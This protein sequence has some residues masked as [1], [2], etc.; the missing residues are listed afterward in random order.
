MKNFLAPYFRNVCR[1]QLSSLMMEQGFSEDSTYKHVA[2]VVFTRKDVAIKVTY[3]PEDF[4]NYTPMVSV[5]KINNKGRQQFVGLWAIIPEDDEARNYSDLVFSS[6]IECERSIR[7][8]AQRV[9]NR[10]VYP[11][12][13]DQERLEQTLAEQEKSI[14]N[15]YVEGELTR[16]KQEAFKAFKA[17]N[18]RAAVNAFE[19]IP[20]DKLSKLELIQ[21]KYAMN[22][23]NL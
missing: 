7:L 10:F 4:P 9:I 21:L 3:Y 12:C 14:M 18:Y 1:R 19:S 2:G 5:G 15:A 8:I 11:L 16:K 20:L 23:M 13:D 22:H 6:E 17:Q